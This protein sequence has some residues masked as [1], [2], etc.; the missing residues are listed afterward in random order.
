MSARGSLRGGVGDNV[1]ELVHL[2]HRREVRRDAEDGVE[3]VGLRAGL[4]GL[5]VERD[6]RARTGVLRGLVRAARVH[7]R[8]AHELRDDVA[9][10][11]GAVVVRG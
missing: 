11:R 3:R 1:A 8:V 10:L 4:R 9:V 6:L 2:G 5:A 7:E